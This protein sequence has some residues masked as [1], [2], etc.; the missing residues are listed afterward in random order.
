MTFNWAWSKGPLGGSGSGEL[1]FEGGALD[2]VFLVRGGGGGDEGD[3]GDDKGGSGGGG[4]SNDGG[5]GGGGHGGAPQVVVV[6]GGAAFAGLRLAV[7]ADSADW[8]YQALLLVF[9]G[10]V[11]RQ[12]E[13]AVDDA[14]RTVRRAAPRAGGGG[15]R[16]FGAGTWRWLSAACRLLCPVLPTLSK[17]PLR[18]APTITTSIKQQQTVGA[19]GDQR[20]ARDRA[21]AR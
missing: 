8:L 11:R 10:A 7:R 9:G 17:R 5:G 13:A 19:G 12:I 15:R 20:R 6:S 4:G 16:C 21:A 3:D 2:A 18:N 1:S 14:L